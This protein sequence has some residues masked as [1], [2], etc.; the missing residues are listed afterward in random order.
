VTDIFPLLLPISTWFLPTPSAHFHS[1][2]PWGDIDICLAAPMKCVKLG[3]PISELL[4]IIN[5]Y[6]F[7][8]RCVCFAYS[9]L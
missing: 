2:F 8:Y 9:R 4:S 7:A 1:I 3:L 5:C 6:Y